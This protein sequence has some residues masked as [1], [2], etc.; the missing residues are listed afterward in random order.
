VYIPVRYYDT[1]KPDFNGTPKGDRAAFYFFPSRFLWR[2][3]EI[4]MGKKKA[5]LRGMGGDTPSYTTG[6]F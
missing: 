4:L 2:T 1:G 3:K 6:S 5:F